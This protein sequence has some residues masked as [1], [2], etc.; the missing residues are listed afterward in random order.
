MKLI[1]LLCSVLLLSVLAVPDSDETMMSAAPEQEAL[2]E[3]RE[4]DCDKF[5]GGTM[6]T[7]QYDPV[8]G[9]DGTTYATICVLC[10]KNRQQKQNVKVAD[11]GPCPQ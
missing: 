11:I 3:P 9:S 5:E 2:A 4:P 7:K 1:V 6:C 8:C 10:Q